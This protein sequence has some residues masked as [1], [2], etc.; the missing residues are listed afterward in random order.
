VGRRIELMSRSSASHRTHHSSLPTFIK[1]QLSQLVK[2]APDGTEWLHEIK[3]DG[4]R[5]HAR[6]RLR[7][8][9]APDPHHP[10]RK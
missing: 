7:R 9:A 4:Y 10:Q 2:S 6:R 3:Y 1:P 5:M 8:R